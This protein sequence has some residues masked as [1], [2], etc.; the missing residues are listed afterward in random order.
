M[1][2]EKVLQD[3]QALYD[4]VHLISKKQPEALAELNRLYMIVYGETVT[5]GCSGC[6]LKAYKKLTSLTLQDLQNMEN[7]KFKIKKGVLIE[8]PFRSGEFVSSASD[9]VTVDRVATAY[10]TAHPSKISEFDVYPGS[11]SESKEF[12]LSADPGKDL[13]RMNKAELQAEYKSVIGE[14]ADDSLTKAELIKEIR[15]K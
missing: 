15:S 14:D 2:S 10:L 5:A 3:I 1:D 11:D 12:Q 4:L 13:S 8:F 6:H 7:Q 9:P